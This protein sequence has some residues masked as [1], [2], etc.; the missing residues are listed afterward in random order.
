MKILLSDFV[1]SQAVKR[2]RENEH[3]H[4]H[5]E[6]T[7]DMARLCDKEK[8]G[9]GF[10]VCVRNI[11]SGGKKEH[12]PIHAYVLT[13]LNPEIEAGCFDATDESPPKSAD[14][15]IDADKKHPLPDDVK[16][17]LVEWANAKSKLY[18]AYT[19]W[20]V[21]RTEFMILNPEFFK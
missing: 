16:Q 7:S 20:Y 18:P 13:K 17:E 4:R 19:N 15:V 1:F 2:R 11:S 8:D 6:N 12:L 21:V 5:F 3:K 10:Y 9:Y 14:D